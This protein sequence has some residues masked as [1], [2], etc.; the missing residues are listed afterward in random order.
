MVKSCVWIR[1]GVGRL[2]GQ[3]GNRHSDSQS[4]RQTAT[5]SNA[6]YRGGNWCPLVEV[7][8]YFPLKLVV[9]LLVPVT[10]GGLASALKQPRKQP[11]SLSLRE[12]ERVHSITEN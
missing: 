11:L 6:K 4:D 12:E 1:C 3:A 9:I 2:G 5:V 8:F 7:W 10:A